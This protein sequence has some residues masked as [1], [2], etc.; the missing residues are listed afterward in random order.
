MSKE[1]EVLEGFRRLAPQPIIPCVPAVV[2]SVEKD[3]TCTVVFADGYEQAD[4][5][6][7]AAVDESKE[8]VI[9]TPRLKSTVLV[10]PLGDESLGEYVVVSVNEVESIVAV[11][12]DENKAFLFMDKESFTVR[13]KDNIV[14]IDQEQMSLTSKKSTIIV[15]ESTIEITADE[16]VAFKTMQTSLKAVLEAIVD[17]SEKMKVL[18]GSPGSLSPA[19]PTTVL[20]ASQAKVLISNLLK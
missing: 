11:F 14:L 15:K 5:R 7:K 1:Q 6:L 3:H 16:A 12:S 19:D 2:K 4:V 10:T 8:Y 13:M 18:T 20:L 17:C 9:I